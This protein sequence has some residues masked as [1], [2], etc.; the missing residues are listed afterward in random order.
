MVYNYAAARVP[1]TSPGTTAN[2]CTC[3]GAAGTKH[4]NQYCCL[5]LQLCSCLIAL[6][7]EEAQT[8]GNVAARLGRMQSR[9]I[10]TTTIPA[11]GAF[12]KPHLQVLE[13]L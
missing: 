7:A 2:P 11:T 12:S 5:H 8:C 4:I 3:T 13:T 10:I 6:L 1:C 9:W